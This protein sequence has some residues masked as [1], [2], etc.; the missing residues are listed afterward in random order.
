LITL[1]L[2]RCGAQILDSP[3]S[4]LTLLAEDMVEKG[5]DQ[6]LF[7]PGFVVSIAISF[8]RGTVRKT[9]GF[10][11]RDISPIKNVN[12]CFIPALFV[13]GAEDDFILPKHSEAIHAK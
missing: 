4:D 11:I 1:A 7:V 2:W 9:A 5:R 6:G 3:F 12:A 10:N 13:S 8:I